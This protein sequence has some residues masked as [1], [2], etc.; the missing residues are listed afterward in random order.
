M[1]AGHP[2]KRI[3]IAVLVVL[4]VVVGAVL[5]VPSFIDW[6]S[7]K[8]QIAERVSA[9][10]GRAVELKGD[11]GLSLLPSPALTVRD[12]RLANAPGG[13]EPDMARLKELDVRVA[14]G[15]L[16]SGRIQVQSIRLI[17]PTFVFEVLPDG[18]FN[19]DLSAAGRKT[20][21][22]GGGSGDGI[23]SSVSFDQ[24]TVKNGTI[25]YRDA[26]TGRS[27]TVDQLDARIVAGSFAG[28]FQG[29]GG[30]RLRGVPLRGE[31]FVSRLVEGAAV[32]VRA[33]L[34]MVDTD[35]TLRFAGIV[36]ST[37]TGASHAQGDLR[38]EG[39]DLARALEPL[40]G[41]VGGAVGGNPALAQAFSVR[42]AVEASAAGASFTNLEGQLG[43]T[44]ATGTAT[45]RAG[46]PAR[47]ELTLGLNRLDLDA[48][49]DRA[50]LDRSGIERSGTAPPAP[51][52]VA[53]PSGNA[54]AAG[55]AAPRPGTFALPEGL[56]AKLDLAVDGITYNGGVVRQGRVEASLA[57]GT[58]NIDRFSALLPG[59][60]DIVAA[61][62]LVAAS[63]QPNLDLRL[64]ANADN[65]RALLEWMK[66]D[67]HAVPADRLRRAS[68]AARL[69]G[70]PG[71][72][73][74]GGLDLRVDTSRLTGAIAYVDRGRP[75][76]GA[77]LDLDR[78]NLDAYLPH[79]ADAAAGTPPASGAAPAQATPGT[80]KGNRAALTP[81]R[82][83]AEVDA[84]LDLTVGQLTVRNMPVQGL[85]VDATAAGGALSIKEAKVDDFAGM[86]GRL[87]GQIAGLSPLRGAHLTLDAEA[88]SLDGL[89]RVVVW[90]AGAPSPERLGAVKAQAR[91][92][93]DAERMAV[94]LTLDAAGGNLEAGGTLLNL[95]KDPAAELKLRTRI[96]EL[97]Q[98]VALFT[99][100]GESGRYGPV[101]L[102]T[103]L[104]GTRKVFAL[105]NIQGTV[106]GTS[107]RGRANA[108]LNGAKPRVD[109]DIQTGDL[110]LDHLAAAPVAA[111][112]PSGGAAQSGTA[113]P[114]ESGGAIPTGESGAGGGALDVGW[115]RGFDGRLL[116][117]SS[118]L[119]KGETRIEHPSLRA[120]V[121]NGV[122]TLEQ[123]DGGLLGGQL[124]IT[125]RLA[126]P[127]GQPATAEADITLVKAQLSEA[128]GTGS[129]ALTGGTLD[130]E[131]SLTTTGT[132]R[133]ALVKG[134]SGKGRLSARD[135][136][137]RGLD[138]GALRDR[139]TK[140][141]RPQELLGAVMGGLQGGETRF[142]SLDGTFAVNGGVVRTDDLRLK[143]AVG[144]AAGAGQIDLP[145][146]SIDMRVRVSILA[147]QALP[148]LTLRLTGPLDKPTR[149]FEMQEVQEYFARRAAEGL[150]NRLAPKDGA[151]PDAGGSAPAKPETLL[152]GLIEGLRR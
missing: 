52:G 113:V 14:L 35:A 93:G 144:D 67:V 147:D 69:Q 105:A 117:T 106:A 145:A 140:L 22:A 150:L 16:L 139:L 45:L 64:E 102:Y 130:L 28:P 96:P 77:R 121:Q 4:A 109:A 15:P 61:G 84:N 107:L 116:L 146:N 11:I 65:L 68:L 124:G 135:G 86:K 38:I 42:T 87:D 78:L 51:G 55:T 132:T 119:V 37:P 148:P 36:T 1:K 149:S 39:T 71:R 19:W 79:P 48:W 54:P 9:A 82:L 100:S 108:D 95:E 94:E 59:G 151:L 33:S 13:S 152:K 47:A 10:T 138:I 58:L 41:M 62:E 5:I 118:A 103:E 123:F 50:G 31:M 143:S 29:Q 34:S 122:L 21:A 27:E 6:N 88:A 115:L 7:Y 2:V 127:G 99:D 120:A 133:D 63:G 89:S 141:E 98:L 73:D 112:R 92:A 24:V 70:R 104:N 74:V 85:R 134:L 3:L 90:P 23:A 97:G 30:F 43:D 131:S 66:V 125:G 12:A 18:R 101:D 32:Q 17:D 72:L 129:L 81:A 40:R 56:D 46:N 80:G 114:G 76:F 83:L 53:A 128:F 137:I 57:G 44:R 49:I 142:A 111:S 126:A 26:R 60:S 25:L 75:A 136:V 110:D 8:A 91:I 20:D